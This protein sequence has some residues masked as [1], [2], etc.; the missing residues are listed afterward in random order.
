[1][2]FF[3]RL[4][5]AS[6]VVLA[7][8]GCDENYD[9]ENIDKTVRIAVNDL[10]IPINIDQ[11][12]L[13]DIIDT[14]DNVQ[15]VDGA[16]AYINNGSFDSDP[17]TFDPIDAHVSK[18]T[19]ASLRL[20]GNGADL[21]YH[22]DTP[23][24][25]N[26]EF[27]GEQV[28][29]TVED[30][31]RIYASTS[32]S[33]TLNLS[34]LKQ[35]YASMEVSGAKLQLPA[36]CQVESMSH[37]GAYDS[38]TGVVTLDPFTVSPVDDVTFTVLAS[39]VD[40]PQGSFADHTL[41]VSGQIGFIDGNFVLQAKGAF[42]PDFKPLD[43]D[44]TY[45]VPDFTVTAIDG[46][47]HYDIEGFDIPRIDITDLPDVLDQEGT[48]LRLANPL[49]YMQITNP[50]RQSGVYASTGLELTALRDNEPG[51]SFTTDQ[52]SFL[53]GKGNPM[54]GEFYNYCLSP[55]APANAYPGYD[56]AEHIA[57][58]RL[59][60]LLS[61]N[62]MPDA[63]DIKLVNP[64]LP[65]QK[66]TKFELKRFDGIQGYYTLVAPFQLADG[67]AIVYGKTDR[68]WDSEDLEKLTITTMEINLT[69]TTDVPMAINLT[70][71]PL[72]KNGARISGVS[73]VGA[74]VPAMASNDQ[75]KIVVECPQGGFSG[76]DGIEFTAK[77]SAAA[78]GKA[79][80]PD[81]TITLSN[82]RPKVGG[83]YETTLD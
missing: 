48:D 40:V 60:D 68:N 71:Y 64:V 23:A 49:L 7:A 19:P 26:Y 25:S 53:I 5:C 44:V 66:V 20:A 61:G 73:I 76:L 33:I 22:V 16:Y 17:E 80:S 21:N 51:V 62:G 38:A 32:L 43:I 36:G 70:G 79:L 4:L 34:G 11:I 81:M 37:K 14:S 83:Y 56:N 41:T 54:Q 50:L 55:K 72:D 67:A 8:T 10:V 39:S 74:Q 78:D 3:T 77:A 29:E 52:P 24:L 1:M 31:T 63:I 82:V 35:Q 2:K 59:G 28:H 12:T 13:D 46:I 69:V 57:F 47:I 6:A 15:I 27:S 18:L 45:S 58:S 42:T 75:V 30:V 65:T 9:L